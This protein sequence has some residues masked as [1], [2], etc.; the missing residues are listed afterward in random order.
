MTRLSLESKMSSPSLRLAL[1]GAT[2]GTGAMVLRHALDADH[3]VTAL[4]RSPDKLATAHPNLDVVHGSVMDHDRVM[5]TLRGVDAVI[6]VL[7]APARS[8]DRLRERGTARIVSAMQEAGIRRLVV[9]SSHGIGETAHELPWLMRWLVVPLY[10]K[11]A[12]ADHERQE[13]VVH[14]SGLDWTLVRPPHLSDDAPARAN[15]TRAS[16]SQSRATGYWSR[17]K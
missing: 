1:F 6:C 2:G 8:T 10:L 9:Q 17:S 15:S 13:A 11:R 7:G 14:A 4:V 16:T 3:H 5:Q 12:F